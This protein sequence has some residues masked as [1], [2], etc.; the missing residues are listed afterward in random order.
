MGRGRPCVIPGHP[1]PC[2]ARLTPE[3]VG[4]S[5][6]SPFPPPHPSQQT[7]VCLRGTGGVCSGGQAR[8]GARGADS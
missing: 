8:G 4:L 3:A 2:S 6:L 5:S 7:P 1:R